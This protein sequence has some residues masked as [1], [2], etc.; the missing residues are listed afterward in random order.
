MIRRS[1]FPLACWCFV[2]WVLLSWT[3]TAEQLLFGAG[4]SLLV[5][6]ALSPLGNV[7]GPWRLLLPRN[8]IAALR[9]LGTALVR[10][11]SANLRLARRI[12]SPRL[13]LR[14]GMVVVPT[15]ERSDLGLATVGLVTSLIVD[16]QIVDLDRERHLL[17]Y[18]AV[19]VPD[20]DSRTA[21]AAI[22]EPVERCLEGL[23]TDDDQ[24]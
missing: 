14:S 10:V 5:G 17:Q 9:V 16:N 11:P 24:H 12:W 21:R 8:L 23:R 15:Q 3:R 22:N 4:I 13:P 2:V 19:D 18:H 20:G 1:W 7:P 6:L